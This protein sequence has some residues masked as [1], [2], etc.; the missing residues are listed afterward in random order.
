MARYNLSGSEELRY[1]G[2]YWIELQSSQLQVRSDSVLIDGM[3]NLEGGNFP[4]S[5]HKIVVSEYFA[6]CSRE[7]SPKVRY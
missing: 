2:R 7:Y 4:V 3:I 6:C 1:L 5:D